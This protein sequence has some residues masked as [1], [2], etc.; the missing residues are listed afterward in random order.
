M[1]ESGIN[2][3]NYLFCQYLNPVRGHEGERCDC[4]DMLSQKRTALARAKLE[5]LCAHRLAKQTPTSQT[6][7]STVASNLAVTQGMQARTVQ[8]AVA[9]VDAETWASCELYSVRHL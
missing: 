6:K 7:E 1:S 8:L 4:F 2:K 9:D 5:H 3:H